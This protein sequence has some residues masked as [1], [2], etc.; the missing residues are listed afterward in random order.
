MRE[1]SRMSLTEAWLEIRRLLTRSNVIRYLLGMTAIG[2][3]V[4]PM[5]RSNV[6]VSSWD[7]LNYSIHA[8]VPGIPFGVASGITATTVMVL[9]ILLY[10]NLVYLVMAIPILLVSALILLFDQVVFASLV[11]DAA[12]EHLLGFAFGMTLLPLGG[13]LMISTRLPAG[14]YDEFMLAVLHVAKSSNIPLV[15][16]IIE[17]TVVLIALLLGILAGIGAG[18]INIGTLVFSVLVGVFIRMYLTIM[19]RLGLY[20]TKQTD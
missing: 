17:V 9:T 12:W 15:R 11:Y 10:R 5:I 3:G 4:A 1:M 8:L 16:A 18:K 7:T 13:S 14:V 6:G 2:L 20:E 19:E